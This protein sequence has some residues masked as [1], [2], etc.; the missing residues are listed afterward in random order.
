MNGLIIIDGWEEGSGKGWI[1]AGMRA[2]GRLLC[3]NWSRYH[4]MEM[5]MKFRGWRKCI[6]TLNEWSNSSWWMRGGAWWEAKHGEN[7]NCCWLLCGSQMRYDKIDSRI[8]FTSWMRSNYI[9]ENDVNYSRWMRRGGGREVENS[10]MRR[11]WEALCDN[12]KGYDQ[13][14]AELHS[15]RGKCL[16]RSKM[17]MIIA[18]DTWTSGGGGG[19]EELWKA[20]PG[21]LLI[22]IVW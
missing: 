2:A 7:W 18:V 8:A 21:G 10:E 13:N 19:G 22:V 16:I 17:A 3:E 15:S 6:N 11:G 20:R 4:W 5:S 1:S 12:Q 9:E 14:E